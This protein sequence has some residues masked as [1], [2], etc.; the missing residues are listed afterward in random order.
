MFRNGFG[1]AIPG[2]NLKIGR[3]PKTNLNIFLGATMIL[4]P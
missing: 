1:P 3:K 4:V 2:L